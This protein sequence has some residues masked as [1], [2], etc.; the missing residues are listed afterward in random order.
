MWQFKPLGHTIDETLKWRIAKLQI[1]QQPLVWNPAVFHRVLIV[2]T[3]A[4]SGG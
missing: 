1:A 3:S 4:C 2:S